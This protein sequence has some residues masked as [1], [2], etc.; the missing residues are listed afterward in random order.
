MMQKDSER[1]H[2]FES[3][4]TMQHAHLQS[5]LSANN[6]EK[7]VSCCRRVCGGCV[8]L[9]RAFKDL[10]EQAFFQTN[11]GRYLERLNSILM[12]GSAI[13]YVALSYYEQQEGIY[14]S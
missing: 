8:R 9:E 3:S 12:L 7:K 4:T 10:L 1:A 11:F 6:Q 14:E 2:F 5:I 13:L